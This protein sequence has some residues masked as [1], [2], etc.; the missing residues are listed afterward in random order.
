MHNNSS[1]TSPIR[2]IAII[3]LPMVGIV[4]PAIAAS[5]LEGGATPNLS[6]SILTTDV[7]YHGENGSAKQTIS[8]VNVSSPSTTSLHDVT[9]NVAPG[10]DV[11][12]DSYE[13][14][15]DVHEARIRVIDRR[16]EDSGTAT[17]GFTRI[18]AGQQ[19]QVRFQVVPITL[20]AKEVR[21]GHLEL[22]Y[23]VGAQDQV[24]LARTVTADFSTNVFCQLRAAKTEI[25]TL[26]TRLKQKQAQLR[27]DEHCFPQTCV[28]RER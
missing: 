23:Q 25:R 20:G 6:E 4:T 21:V 14:T 17:F 10:E 15:S 11:L 9:L 27:Y 5:P 24:T 18:P 22:T 26:E 28:S 1:P 19:T 16:G 8:V 3:L 13:Q 7:E 2:R 12:L